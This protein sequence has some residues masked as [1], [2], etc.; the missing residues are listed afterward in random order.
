[1]KWSRAT[2]VVVDVVTV[3]CSFV[4]RYWPLLGS[5]FKDDD[6]SVLSLWVVVLQPR[7]A[8]SVLGG[9]VDGVLKVNGKRGKDMSYGYQGATD[10]SIG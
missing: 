8:T 2:R 9:F 5:R 6:A 10:Y 4:W 3:V 7:T 1:M